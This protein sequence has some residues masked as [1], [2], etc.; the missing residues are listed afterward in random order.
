MGR[1]KQLLEIGGVPVIRRVVDAASA[2]TVDEVVVVVGHEAAAVERVLGGAPRVR[3]VANPDHRAGQSTSLRAGLAAL[4]PA[5]EAAVVLL[6][7]QPGVATAAIDA[8]AD[9][10]R[11]GRGPV[12]RAAYSGR[13]GHP[14]LCD[15]S[16]WAWVDEVEGDVGLR[17]VLARHPDRIAAVEV[18]G[19]PPPDIDT[20]EDFL[21]V[22]AALEGGA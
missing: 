1:P 19:D 4:G 6:G 21:R 14:T 2:S 13:P 20:E 9:A 11:Q 8:V 5:V 22:R 17:D 10:W 7:D 16:A 15:R 3:T 12:V 18:G